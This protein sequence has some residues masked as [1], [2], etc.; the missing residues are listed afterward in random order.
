MGET[1]KARDEMIK[2][3]QLDPANP[4]CHL[5][6]GEVY[7]RQRDFDAARRE[8]EKAVE[9]NPRLAAAYYTLGGVYRHLGLKTQAESAYAAFQTEQNRESEKEADRVSEAIQGNASEASGP[10]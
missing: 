2:A 10:R 3:E 8:L 7:A 1:E 4:H 6:L 5:S 9:I